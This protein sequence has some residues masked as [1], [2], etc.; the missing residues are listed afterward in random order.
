MR[1]GLAVALAGA[2]TGALPLPGRAAREA[3]VALN[4][5]DVDLPVLARFVSEVTGR[6][7]IL[8]DRVRGTVTII[9]PTRITPDEAYLVFQSVLQVKGFTTVPSGRFTKIVP[10][11]DGREEAVPPGAG[12]EL[13]TRILPLRHADAAAA[14][15]VV[16]PL[17]SKDGILTAYPPTNRLVVVDARSNVDRIAAVVRD[18][19]VPAVGD[20]ATESLPLR[21][22]PA[23]ELA[24][25]LRQAL[26]GEADGVGGLRVVP[27]TRTNSL[28][29]SGPPADVARARALAARLDVSAPGASQ[30]HVY[31]LRFA[32][33]E[34]LV[35]VLSQLL[36]LP[37]PPPAPARERGSSIMRAGARDAVTSPPIGYDGG[38]GEPPLAPPPPP[39]EPV[40]TGTRGAIPLEAPVRITAD[41][42]TNTLVVSATPADWHTLRGVITDLDVRRRQVFVE[43]IILEAT[44]D[45]L[46]ELGIE[47][48]GA[49]GLGGQNIGFGQ[50]NLSALGTAAL[51]PTSLPG[52]LLAA[53]SNQMVTLPNGQEV[54]AYTALLTA[55]ENQT[56]ID[57][58]SAPNMVTTDNEEAEIVVGRN[59]PFVASRATSS[60]NLSNLFTT[61]ERRDVGITLR[62]TPR[63]TADDF[64]HLEL[65][66]EVSDIDPIP[67]PAIGD[68]TQVGPTT[69]I[70]SASTVVGARD[71]Q[72]VV[73]GGLLADTVRVNERGVPY[74]KD[75]P[76][77]GNLFKRDDTRRVKTNLLVF[78]TPH[79]IATD[80]QM[81][82]N[83]LRERG[84]MPARLR[85]SPALRGK[86]WGDPGQGD[87][88]GVAPGGPGR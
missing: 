30:L 74:L 54:P 1:L 18:L 36:G 83:S 42:A 7:F 82:E 78:L 70:R 80:R 12:D 8:D 19:D 3:T 13:V 28:L 73:I 43:G 81:A 79:V 50:V 52:L 68:P 88:T 17:V 58:L 34:S 39:P 10:V 49:T 5:Q 72:T 40:S 46:R 55:L 66:E 75:V 38:M 48:R 20:R 60:S 22:A 16:Q 76:V 26:G 63:I 59:V 32:Q 57:V 67:N 11:R 21:Y 85:R 86:S 62:L 51:D 15:P 71:G 4:F 31:R 87:G 24:G 69:T 41:P 2:L 27:E 9:S 37:P 14:V 29:L 6:N 53:A 23:D 44:T 35:R 56:D 77:L 33:A 61:I 84:R 47:L 25:R 64:V 65:F 45:R